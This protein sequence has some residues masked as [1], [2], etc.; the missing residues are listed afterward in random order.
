MSDTRT[1]LPGHGIDVI[2]VEPDVIF[3][4]LALC[5]L[6]FVPVLGSI[7]VH[8]WRGGCRFKLAFV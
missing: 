4:V 5:G 3:A 2:T 7:G 8:C 6:I 1:Q